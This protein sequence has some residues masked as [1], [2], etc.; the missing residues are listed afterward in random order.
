[1]KYQYKICTRHKFA[2][3]EVKKEINRSLKKRKSL[4]IYVWHLNLVLYQAQKE[5]CIIHKK[6]LKVFKGNY[7]HSHK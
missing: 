4:L 5:Q 7:K 3:R 6:A 2:I 1:M